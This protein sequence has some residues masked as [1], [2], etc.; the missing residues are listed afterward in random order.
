MRVSERVETWAVVVAAG[1][2][3]RLGAR[4]PKA[5]VRFR[6]AALVA[7][8]IVVLDQH[9]GIDGVV[10]VVPAGYEE[11]LGLIADDVGAGKVAA[12]VAGGPTRADSVRL[13]LAAIPASARF[14]TDTVKR[15]DD[16]GAVRETLER[17]TLRAAQTPQGFPL[18][19]LREAIAAAGDALGAAGDC[20]SLVEAAGRTVVCVDGDADNLKITHAADLARA[21]G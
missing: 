3:E 14:V 19:V 20:A 17:T 12:A 21:E 5:F 4:E 11:R 9:D 7:A 6:G 1:S 18:E 2:G 10:C 8:S 16:A 15:V 13:A